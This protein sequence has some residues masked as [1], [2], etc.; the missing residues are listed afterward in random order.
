[1]RTLPVVCTELL[2]SWKHVT[3]YLTA[4][5]PR[6]ECQGVKTRVRSIFHFSGQVRPCVPMLLANDVQRDVNVQFCAN[7][8]IVSPFAGL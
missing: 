4:A 2:S 7:F 6:H 3:E 5:A 8:R 1:M